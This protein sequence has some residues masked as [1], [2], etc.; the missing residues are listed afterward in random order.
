MAYSA[1]I[2][3]RARRRLEEKRAEKESRF[4][5]NQQIAYTKLP[6]LQE[7]D[8]ALRSSMAQAARAAFVNGEDGKAA[9]E[10][11]RRENLALQQ[12]YKTLVE[13]NFAPD[14]LDESPIC[15]HCGGKGYVG[16]TMCRCLAELCLE[17]Q[18]R[19]LAE[20]TTGKERFSGF[21]LDYYPD[22]LDPNYGASPRFIMER[23]LS[24]C[25][26]YAANFKPDIGNV[27]FVGGTGLGKTFLSACIANEVVE[28]GY[29]IAY[30]SAPQLFA[31]LERDRFNPDEES[32]R[33]VKSLTECD[34]LIIDDL[35]T[36]MAGSFVT[37]AFYSLLS[38]RLL[39]GKAMI[40]STNL[41]APEIA[42]RYSP[43][44][45]SRIQGEFKGLTFVGND[46][47]V[48]KG[49]GVL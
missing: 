28:K 32:Q 43:Q 45:A 9:L 36:E 11:V 27:L 35:G 26:Q 38:Q 14:F 46:I 16:A 5:Q 34:L 24:Y 31:K 3:Q 13:A 33:Q 49:R 37:A 6:R 48:L 22:Q 18:R 29:S 10:K 47:R 2:M 7:I 44:I 21:R 39:A 40:I 8:I 23:T 41:T 25:K 15:P 1:E 4:R 42:Q 19:E 20:L 30:E 17:E 12:E